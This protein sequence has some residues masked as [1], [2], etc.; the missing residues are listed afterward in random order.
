MSTAS[1][2]TSIQES[3]PF[4]LASVPPVLFLLY[5]QWSMFGNPF[6]PGQYWM[7]DISESAFNAAFEN[8][9]AQEGFRGFTLPKLDLYFLNLFDPS[10]GMYAYGPLLALGLIP[11]WKY[12]G[13][14]IL[15]RR[16]RLFVAAFVFAFLTFNA[17]NQFSRIQFNSGFRYLVP[18]VPFIFLAVSDHLVRIP[19]KW[20]V[21][22]LVPVFMN[23]WVISMVREPVG[24]CWDSVIAK[25]IQLP[26]LSVLAMTQPEGHPVS[27]PF[28]PLAVLALAAGAIWML[29]KLPNA[30]P[31]TGA[32]GSS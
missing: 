11:A 30:D 22:L 14:L 8:P 1:V 26:W 5:S 19:R 7:P 10:Y 31:T 24:E 9:Y 13:A 18:L 23:S 6:M 28:A 29:W 2:K 15:P 27:S 12:K 3:I 17:A 16:E 32:A 25:G 21:T 4:V 20:L